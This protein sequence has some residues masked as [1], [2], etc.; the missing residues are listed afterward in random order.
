MKYIINAAI[1]GAVLQKKDTPHLPITDDEIIADAI[2]VIE[3]GA[4]MVHLHVRDEN[5]KNSLNKEQYGYVI[6]SLRQKYPDVIYTVSCS[7]RYEPDVEK[8]K[9]PLFL[10]NNEKPDMASLT[11][12][13]MNFLKEASVN[14]PN[15]VQEL[16]RTMME[17]NIKPE[18]EVFDIGMV[19]YSKY[20]IKKGLLQ[21]PYYYNILLG[22]IAGVQPTPTDISA[23]MSALPHDSIICFSGLGDYQLKSN[24]L[25]LLFANG[26]RIGLED[27]IYFERESNIL[28]TNSSL[29][30]R[31][32]DTTEPLGWTPMTPLEVRH[33]LHLQIPPAN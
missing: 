8:R 13:S 32:R 19:H 16:A 18:L 20:L 26:I 11:L 4:S 9:E 10:L 23:I 24:L 6:K 3:K 31:I 33:L 28:A 15:T 14:S 7:G 1:T 21:P 2:Q 12:S 30:Q 22:N 17:K 27:N 25:G 5:G 29:I